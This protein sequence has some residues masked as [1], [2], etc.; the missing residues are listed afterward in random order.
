M[1]YTMNRALAAT[2]QCGIII[3]AAGCGGADQAPCL[4]PRP[5]E[6][7]SFQ[8]ALDALRVQAQAHE[9]INP[10]PFFA[11]G[12]CANGPVYLVETSRG[13]R[14]RYFDAATGAFIGQTLQSDA[15]SEPCDGRTYWP[16]L[17][18]C[19]APVITEVICGMHVGSPAGRESSSRVQP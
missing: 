2:C 13:S 16:T 18:Q 9:C 4:S 17:V 15:I 3:G 7:P 19:D 12:Q 1:Y 8:E 6:L 11:A 10:G 14:T 5:L